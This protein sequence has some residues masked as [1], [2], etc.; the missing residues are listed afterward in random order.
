MSSDIEDMR[1]AIDDR[2]GE[3]L[4]L[5]CAIFSLIRTQSGLAQA[6]FLREFDV[7]VEHARTALLNSPAP[8]RTAAAFDYYVDA[9]NSSRTD[10]PQTPRD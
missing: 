6:K 9:L 1:K 3:L 8:D 2:K 7:E 5:Q 10:G 4:A